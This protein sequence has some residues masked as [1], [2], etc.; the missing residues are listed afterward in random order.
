MKIV[1]YSDDNSL[2]TL[3]KNFP[4]FEPV[5]TTEDA[6]VEKLVA[7][8]QVLLII[9]Y[10]LGAE[11]ANEINDLFLGNEK[12]FR[13]AVSGDFTPKQLKKL[14]R[15]EN[16]ADGY[17]IKPLTKENIDGLL[18][19]FRMLSGGGQA[20]S[21][22]G[23]D[24]EE[25]TF[26]GRER[27]AINPQEMT[28]PTEKID[29]VEESSEE[30][31]FA[32]AQESVETS[33]EDELEFTSADGTDS[34]DESVFEEATDP[35]ISPMH[36]ETLPEDELL[37]DSPSEE[38][39][40]VQEEEA[41]EEITSEIEEVTPEEEVDEGPEQEPEASGE[42]D[43]SKTQE[44]K[45]RPEE[46]KDSG[47]ELSLSEEGELGELELS[48]KRPTDQ[49]EPEQDS[50]ETAET[51]AIEVSSEEEDT[52]EFQVN[53]DSEA[54][55]IPEVTDSGIYEEQ[56]IPEEQAN[57]L[58]EEP[59]AT[60]S[61]IDKIEYS[62]DEN[63]MVK[64]QIT[65][66]RMREERGALLKEIETLRKENQRLEQEGLGIRA[67]LDEAQIELSI[68]RKRHNDEIEDLKHSIKISEEKK[69][70]YEEKNK[71]FQ[72][73]F[74]RLNQKLRVDVKQVRHR[75]KELESQ[76]EL[77]A[78]DAENQLK[79]RDKKIAE[80]QRK[81]DSLEFNM[82]N[83]SINEQKLKDEKRMLEDKMSK[84][85]KTLRNS[86]KVLEDDVALDDDALIEKLNKL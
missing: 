68:I 85:M 55:E 22:Q 13:V 38:L 26:V 64:S 62:Y 25:M 69:K 18:E 76:L 32:V 7:Q 20:D 5:F 35:G 72:Q 71:N 28:A 66:R 77:T 58:Q 40:P 34:V 46:K 15:Q 73:E 80:L 1:F 60:L 75:E 49:L 67:E 33:S 24:F 65:I 50:D 11:R 48:N 27:S 84:I 52:G 44:F 37:F 63:E 53:I 81:I 31:E 39:E 83:I 42:I 14:Q 17:F 51:P 4:E 47:P 10:E 70:L 59:L 16:A 21:G 45:Y 3:A 78:M 12:V 29:L 9:D 74:D 79:S 86:I 8:D 30:L 57:I 2:E 82:E 56:T 54:T 19:D 6:E 61:Q 41:L 23:D 36:E 43:F